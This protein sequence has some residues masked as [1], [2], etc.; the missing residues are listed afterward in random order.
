M[1]NR[2]TIRFSPEMLEQIYLSL[3][4]DNVADFS[5]W[6]KHACKEQLL[7]ERGI[8]QNVVDEMIAVRRNLDGIGRNINQLARKAN[9]GDSVYLND[10]LVSLVLSEIKN[11]KT[12]TLQ[13]LIKSGY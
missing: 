1:P 9:S 3:G 13:I 8:N 6:V 5:K 12:D 10:E 11:F 2:K 7:H 4:S